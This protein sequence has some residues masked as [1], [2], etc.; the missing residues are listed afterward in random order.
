MTSLTFRLEMRRSRMIALWLSVVVVVYGGIV[1]AMF[2]ILEENAQAFEDYMAIFPEDLL[3][4]FGMTGSLADPG[5]F[6]TTY[7]GSMLWPVVAAIAAIILATRPVAADVERG[8]TEVVLGTRLAR[9][10]A[11]VAAFLAQALVLAILAAATVAGILG[12][13]WVVGAGFEAG[14]FFAASVI[15]WLFGCAVAG[16]TSLLGA[17][18]LSR[19][20]AGGLVAGILILMY[21][22]NV[23]AQVQPDLGWLADLGAFK[24]LA[25][26]EL[27]DEGIVPWASVSVFTVVAVAGWIAAIVVFRR[28]DLLA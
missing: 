1:A 25:V 14:P 5:V 18:T 21:L 4:A 28:R 12:A 7:I 8:W 3:A 11:L 6:F 27:V 16:T 2:P 9:P 19:A 23:V 10:A 24:Y 20:I 17:V 15:M 13:G 22:M 26:T